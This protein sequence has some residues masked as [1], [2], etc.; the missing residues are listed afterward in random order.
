MLGHILIFLR[1]ASVKRAMWVGAAGVVLAILVVLAYWWPMQYKKQQLAEEVNT[2]RR[3]LVSDAEAEQLLREYKKAKK[4]VTQL[5]TK[6]KHQSSQSDL[7]RNI[8]KLARK[9]RIRII[10]EAYDQTT[11]KGS[12]RGLVLNLQLQG[13]YA[14]IRAFVYGIPTLPSW[15]VVQDARFS[16][17]RSSGRQ[18]KANLRLV[19]Y[20]LSP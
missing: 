12:Y 10:S 2:L 1:E 15:T 19:T 6:L 5:Q 7:V 13:R 14:A 17:L 4:Q 3:V 20:R 11:A 8:G 18:V 9:H 16:A